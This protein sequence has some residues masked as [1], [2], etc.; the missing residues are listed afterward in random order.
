[1][2]NRISKQRIREVTRNP[3]ESKCTTY[4]KCKYILS[5]LLCAYFHCFNLIGWRA[6]SQ[7]HNQKTP[8]VCQSRAQSIFHCAHISF[9]S[10]SFFLF[11][12]RLLLFSWCCYCCF[13]V[14]RQT[15]H[16]PR[17]NTTATTGSK[18]YVYNVVVAVFIFFRFLFHLLCFLLL[19]LFY[20]WKYTKRRMRVIYFIEYIF[21]SQYHIFQ[22]E[23]GNS[24]FRNLKYHNTHNFVPLHSF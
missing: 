18:L 19:L 15:I 14:F 8:T 11:L 2:V 20:V 22:S 4:K 12:T 1:M 9:F 10:F 5:Y 3:A 13:V 21:W 7:S 17:S 6:T 24:T 16:L 23:L